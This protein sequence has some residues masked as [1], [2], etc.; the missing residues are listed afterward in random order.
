MDSM[1]SAA[2]LN[3]AL[4]DRFEWRDVG[5]RWKSREPYAKG[6]AEEPK[7]ERIL[8][9]LQEEPARRFIGYIGPVP[10]TIGSAHGK[11]PH[12]RRAPSSRDDLAFS[13][14]VA[15]GQADMQTDL[16]S[17]KSGGCAVRNFD[18]PMQLGYRVDFGIV[19]VLVDYHR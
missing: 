18:R 7:A 14:I 10:S 8:L 19:R 4:L 17:I 16:A 11:R 15:H 12:G 5:G 3:L 9:N 2:L 6:A 13:K 1:T